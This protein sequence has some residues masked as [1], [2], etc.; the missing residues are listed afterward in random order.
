[1]YDQINCAFLIDIEYISRKAHVDLAR[2]L[3]RIL[4]YVQNFHVCYPIA[5][6]SGD[7]F[8]N[9]RVFCRTSN[10]YF[11][12]IRFWKIFKNNIFVQ[13][14]FCLNSKIKTMKGQTASLTCGPIQSYVINIKSATYG[15]N[16]ATVCS[17][18]AT[19]RQG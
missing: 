7:A 1:M 13:M 11:F 4:I 12:R 15:R 16:S 2:Q 19:C 14:N 18:Q 17:S 8:G 5:F 6:D 10:Y 3:F 9:S